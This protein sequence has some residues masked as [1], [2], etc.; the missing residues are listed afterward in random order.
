MITVPITKS[1]QEARMAQRNQ[2]TAAAQQE[3]IKN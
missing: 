3:K 2:V 1:T